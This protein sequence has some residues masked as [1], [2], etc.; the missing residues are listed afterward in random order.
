M[1]VLLL[2]GTGEARELATLI[3]RAGMPAIASL[4][5]VTDRPLGLKLQTRAGGFGG[6][7]PFKA[8]LKKENITAV[9]DATH[10][11]AHRIT[12]RTADICRSLS[13]PYLQ[14][15]RPAWQPDPGDDWHWIDDPSEAS[16]LIPSGATVFL[17]TGRQS[18]AD[19]SGLEGRRVIA[20]VIDPPSSPFPFDGGEF[21]IGRPPF[22]VKS[23]S[24]LLD[25]LGVDWVVT[26]DAGGAASRSK[27]D[28]AFA[29]GLPVAILRRPAMPDAE[30]VETAPEAMQWLRALRWR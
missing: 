9:V 14:V 1:K 30:R 24:A 3:D 7:E 12:D 19:F 16:T 10:P 5:G 28:A 23:E 2:A 8:F 15:L 27:L 22:S 4:A 25:R 17:A 26:K 21:I 13:L 11:F 20:R 6:T 29:L 18:L